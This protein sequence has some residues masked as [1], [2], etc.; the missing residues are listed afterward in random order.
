MS[1]FPTTRMRRL[2]QLPLLRNMVRETSL[3]PDNFILPLF[4]RPGKGIRTEI[5]SMP[6]NYQLSIDRLASE[7]GPAIDLGIRAFLLFGIPAHKD[8]TGSSALEDQGIVQQALRSLRADF[9]DSI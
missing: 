2:R 3:A 5:P 9:R 1:N 4:V 6:G 8:A 7:V